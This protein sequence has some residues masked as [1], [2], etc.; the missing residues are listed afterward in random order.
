VSYKC[1]SHRPLSDA[2]AILQTL[3][4][5]TDLTVLCIC[6]STCHVHRDREVD[7]VRDTTERPGSVSQGQKSHKTHAIMSAFSLLPPQHIL[8]SKTLA[9]EQDLR[10]ASKESIPT[11]ATHSPTE[12][13]NFVQR[14]ST[15]LRTRYQVSKVR[16]GSCN[17]LHKR[18]ATKP[19][20][21]EYTN[22]A[23]TTDRHY[24]LIQSEQS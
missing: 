16:V 5:F 1:S 13:T 8:T 23:S 3:Y 21:L 10:L 24:Y 17:S 19:L 18:A 6:W 12:E 15:A 11:L 7:Q 22:Q 20:K 2:L 9:T 14:E 4:I